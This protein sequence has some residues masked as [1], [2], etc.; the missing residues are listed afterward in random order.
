MNENVA[1]ELRL[2]G[3]LE[4]WSSHRH[5]MGFYYRVGSTARYRAYAEKR[6]GS[7]VLF[8]ALREVIS[9]HATLGVSVYDEGTPQTYLVRLKTIDLSEVVEFRSAIKTSELDAATAKEV[10]TRFPDLG[11]LPAWRVVVWPYEDSDA[12]DVAFFYHHSLG[13]GGSGMAFH[14][15]LLK[16][17]NGLQGGSNSGGSVVDVP[18]LP[19]LPSLE[20]LLPL[21]QSPW[22]MAKLIWRVCTGAK[23]P[24]DLWTGNVIGGFNLATHFKHFSVPGATVTELLSRCRKEKTTMTAA[25]QV[26][27]A[28]AIFSVITEEGC[29]KLSCNTPINLRRFMDGVDDDNMGVFVASMQ[30]LYGRAES[31]ETA[32]DDGRFWELARMSKRAIEKKIAKGSRDLDSGM[33]PY[34][35][36]L[37]KYFESRIGLKRGNSYEVSNV[38]VF[39]GQEG[40]WKVGR[41]MF[42]QSASNVGAAIEFSVASMKG[43]D[44]CVGV[45][46]QEEVVEDKIVEEIVE[47]LEKDLLGLTVVN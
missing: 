18:V 7:E 29:S 14:R 5:H 42:S 2:V 36:D 16:A 35:G 43:G 46:W 9:Q 12:V 23:Y 38:G 39:V 32:A 24:S 17:L 22:T 31:L 41:V 30:Q 47:Q 10:S 44:M 8:P 4:R 40:E 13:D 33:I 21:P 34:A 3:H 25:L 19:L 15:A 6:L 20:D 28:R 26:V 1:E 37:T 11:R 45:S 27:T